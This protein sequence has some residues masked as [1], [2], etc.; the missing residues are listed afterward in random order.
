[1]L[2]NAQM[3]QICNFARDIA[4]REGC[5]LYDL[6]FVQGSGRILR[7][8]IDKSEGVS[9]DDCVNVSKGLNLRLDV[10]DVIPGGRYE[11]EVSSPGMDRKLTKLWHFEGAVDQTVLLKY[12]SEDGK[13]LSF[14]GRLKEVKGETLVLENSKGSVELPFPAI[15]KAKIVLVEP[16]GNSPAKKKKR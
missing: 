12:R 10:E 5:R 16:F 7:V 9:I 1:M 13:V 4:E 8:F 11:L 14:E 6:E 15:E 2:S 3:E